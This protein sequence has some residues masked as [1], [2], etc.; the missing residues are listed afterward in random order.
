[1]LDPS[2]IDVSERFARLTALFEDGA[3]ISSEGQNATATVSRL[4]QQCK[5]L[6]SLLAGIL[7]ELTFIERQL[8]G[9]EA[10]DQE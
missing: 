2:D 9:H 5:Y 7:C 4:T 10:R 6:R 1:M 8:I 3:A